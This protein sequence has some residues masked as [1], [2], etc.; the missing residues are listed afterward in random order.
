MGVPGLHVSVNVFD[1]ETHKRLFQDEVFSTNAVPFVEE[2]AH[3]LS[4][5]ILHPTNVIGVSGPWPN[6]WHRLINAVRDSG[7][8]PTA[9]IPDNAYALTYFPNSE[10]ACHHD[11][12]TKWREYVI[13]VSLGAPFTLT[14]QYAAP[15]TSSLFDSSKPRNYEPPVNGDYYTRSQNGSTGFSVQA[16]LMATDNDISTQLHVCHIGIISL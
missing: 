13:C 5:C 10:F 16:S 12:R 3:P 9:T 2:Q 6:D 1:E 7:L 4:Q 14:F 15:R 11:G 8:F